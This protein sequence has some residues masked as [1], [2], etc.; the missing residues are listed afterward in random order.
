MPLSDRLKEAI[1][2]GFLDEPIL[3][4]AEI[5][6]PSFPE[7][8][9]FV[10]NHVDVD[11]G[12]VTYVGRG[13]RLALPEQRPNELP[14]VAV[15]LDNISREAGKLL[16]SVGTQNTPQPTVI[17]WWALASTPDQA[18]E[19]PFTFR[20]RKRGLSADAITL[21]LGDRELLSRGFPRKRFILSNFP[22]LA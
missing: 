7:P 8:L 17:V 13:M 15:A 6:H 4:F 3:A 10:A 22:G 19:G 14:E 16:R 12:D 11:V 18:E 9:R 2:Q 21:T 20:V 5:N 1:A